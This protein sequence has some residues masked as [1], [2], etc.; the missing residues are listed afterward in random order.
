MLRQ[1]SGRWTR[2]A[3]RQ[4]CRRAR[5]AEAIAVRRSQDHRRSVWRPPRRLATIPATIHA[6][7]VAIH[8][9][10]MTAERSAPATWNHR[11]KIGS[12]NSSRHVAR[13]LE[14][15]GNVTYRCY[16]TC[17]I[18]FEQSFSYDRSTSGL[19]TLDRPLPAARAPGRR[20][21]SCGSVRRRRLSASSR[22]RGG[23]CS[24]RRRA[25]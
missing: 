15:I 9:S 3:S 17:R 14:A 20:R 18:D 25:C 22:A 4:D 12:G 10:P 16:P 24:R 1:R 21:P 2:P 7:A 8:D 19:F 5:A 11:E 6:I 23:P 13:S